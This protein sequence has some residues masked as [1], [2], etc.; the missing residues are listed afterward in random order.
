MMCLRSLCAGLLPLLAFH[1][2]AYAK[3]IPETHDGVRIQ[4]RVSLQSSTSSTLTNGTVL[5]VENATDVPYPRGIVLPVAEYALWVQIT[6]HAELGPSLSML[7]SY[8]LLNNFKGYTREQSDRYGRY[9]PIADKF[10]FPRDGLGV[11]IKPSTQP[12]RSRDMTWND[13]RGAAPTIQLHFMDV[14]FYPS[15]LIFW[16]MNFGR[17]FENYLGV[18]AIGRTSATGLGD[19]FLPDGGVPNEGYVLNSS[20]SYLNITTY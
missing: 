15:S 2:S 3:P 6:P 10:L 5:H 18:G 1:N 12:G 4:E 7:A 8:D 17:T 13:L 11:T 16:D 20:A 14:E 9:T 19:A